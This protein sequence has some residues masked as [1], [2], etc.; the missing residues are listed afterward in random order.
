MYGGD[1][2][3]PYPGITKHTC[4]ISNEVKGKDI[5]L[6]DDIYTRTINIDEDAIEALLEKRAKSVV[7]Y[8]VAKTKPK[9]GSFSPSTNFSSA[10]TDD[11]PF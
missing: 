2:D 11:L 6:I 10:N 3:M 1:G 4:K 8:S 5:L 7:F 9:S